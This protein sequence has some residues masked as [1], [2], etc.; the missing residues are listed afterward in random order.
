M[1]LDNSDLAYAGIVTLVDALNVETLLADPDLEKPVRQQIASA[2]LVILSKCERPDPVQLQRLADLGSRPPVTL[3]DHDIAPL[4]LDLVPKPNRQRAAAHPSY[5]TWQHDSDQ[6]CDRRALGDKLA[7][8]PEGLYRLKGT[9][10]TTGGAYELHVVGRHVEA[11]RTEASRTVL[12]GLGL[13]DRISRQ[14]IAD[15]WGD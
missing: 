9:V 11:R 8:R 13:K 15:W 12:V 3:D 6:V 4:L 14:D 10:L 5:V 1:I 2:D 7:Q